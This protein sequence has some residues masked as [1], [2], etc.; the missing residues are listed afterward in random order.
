MTKEAEEDEGTC[1]N[2]LQLCQPFECAQGRYTVQ[3][4][5]MGRQLRRASLWTPLSRGNGLL[6][7]GNGLLSRGNSLLSSGNSLLIR[8]NGLLSRSSSFLSRGTSLLQGRRELARA[9][10]LYSPSGPH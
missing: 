4:R 5:R 9:P 7:R 6:S 10:G 3:M 2:G 1:V 8:G